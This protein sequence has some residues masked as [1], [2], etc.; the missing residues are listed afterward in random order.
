VIQFDYDQAD[1]GSRKVYADWVLRPFNPD[2][3]I[4]HWGGNGREARGVG[5][6]KQFL[7]NWQSWHIYGRGWVD[8][9]YAFAVGNTGSS[10][11]LRGYNRSGAQ[12][13]DY[14]GDGIKENHEALAIIWIGGKAGVISPAA[15]ATMNRLV[16][17]AGF[18]TLIGHREVIPSKWR[19]CP[20]DTWLAWIHNPPP[21]PPPNMEDTMWPFYE[22][23][24]YNEPTAPGRTHKRS[25]VKWLQTRMNDLG[26][27]ILVD[28]KLGPGT[29]AMFWGLLSAP[30]QAM[31]DG[32]AG[33]AFDKLWA[34]QFAGTVDETARVAAAAADVAAEDAAAD[35][36]EAQVTADLALTG[37]IRANTRLDNV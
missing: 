12:T 31:I 2:K 26:A 14:E 33:A 16:A 28:G 10:Y 3:V 1:W 22:T 19:D 32:V 24:G 21:P 9:A 20:G 5:E 6:E 8:I 27:R 17:E 23:D 18:D 34:E 37:S 4:I 15:F 36:K 11:R 7:R 35:A 25:D 30:T 13:G 29:L